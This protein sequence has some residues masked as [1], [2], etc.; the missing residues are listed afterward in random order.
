MK[1]SLNVPRSK[2]LVRILPKLGLCSRAEAYKAIRAG[3]VAVDGGVVT[4]PNAIIDRPESISI[5]GKPAG[6]SRKRYIIFHKPAG[7]ITT[8]RDEKG[9]RT[10]YDVTGDLGG[11]L[12]PVGRLDKDSEGL[13]ILTNDTRFG[14]YLTDPANKIPRTYTVTVDGD[15]SEAD[16]AK[17]LSGVDIGREERSRAIAARML[18][19]GRGRTTFEITL[20]EGKNREIRRLCMALGVTVRRLVRTRFGAFRLDGLPSGRW[21][22]LDVSDFRLTTYLKRC[23]IKMVK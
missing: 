6:A 20:T 1:K 2:S 18:G 10:V 19:R 16:I 22:E 7:C 4:D 11:R 8:C 5:D 9:R 12:F 13:L 3:R 14:D 17:M 21:Q 23:S 15:L